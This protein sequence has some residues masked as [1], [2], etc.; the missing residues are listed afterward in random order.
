[1]ESFHRGEC[2]PSRL[3]FVVRT[4][5]YC[6]AHFQVLIEYSIVRTRLFIAVRSLIRYS[7]FTYRSSFFPPP[8]RPAS[9]NNKQQPNATVNKLKEDFGGN[10]DSSCI[11]NTLYFNRAEDMRLNIQG[12]NDIS[13]RATPIK[14]RIQRKA[15]NADSTNVRHS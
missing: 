1:M 15:C 2:F 9:T 13:K 8:F 11:M 7:T 10:I 3:E 14:S 12:E 6:I 4:Y 5:F